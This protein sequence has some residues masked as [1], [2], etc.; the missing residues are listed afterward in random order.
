LRLGSL[1][2]QLALGAAIESLPSTAVGDAAAFAAAL[3]AAR[4]AIPDIPALE[5]LLVRVADGVEALRARLKRG[6]RSLAEAGAVRAVALDLERLLAPGWP[7][8]LPWSVL[9]RLDAHLAALSRRLDQA[10]ADPRA[11]QRLAEAAEALA[12]EWDHALGP[13]PRLAVACGLG[14]RLRELAGALEDA[15]LARATPGSS[16]ATGFA[17]KR[18]HDGLAVVA[19]TVAA[20]RRSIAET[21]ERLLGARQQA[22]QLPKGPVAERHLAEVDGL[23]RTYPELGLGC[24]LEGQRLAAIACCER[25]RVAA[26]RLRAR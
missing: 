23:L 5:A 6:S 4:A 12:G 26:E 7:T 9:R 2:R 3:A 25:V 20:V 22:L 14:P 19:K 1:R 11:A 21:R 15:L 17:E 18:L 16:A 8:R 10:N 13:D 24:D